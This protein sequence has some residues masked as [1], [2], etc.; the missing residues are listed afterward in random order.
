MKNVSYYNKLILDDDIL[1]LANSSNIENVVNLD[2]GS[3]VYHLVNNSYVEIVCDDVKESQ[4]H[5]MYREDENGDYEYED[6]YDE[7]T[8][9]YSKVDFSDCECKSI[10]LTSQ[11]GINTSEYNITEAEIIDVEVF[12]ADKTIAQ[13]YPNTEYTEFYQVVA[14]DGS[15]YYLKRICPFFSDKE[16]DTFTQI[17]KEEFNKYTTL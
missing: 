7:E 16:D 6:T 12:I 2:D 14:Q 9:R 5:D 4:W 3:D 17:T 1:R 11:H 8:K 15:I 13:D 10:R